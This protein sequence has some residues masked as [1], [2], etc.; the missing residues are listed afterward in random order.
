[1][2]R[3]G[4]LR[5]EET[6]EANPE[7]AQELEETVHQNLIQQTEIRGAS[8]AATYP[9]PVGTC[10][11]VRNLRNSNRDNLANFLPSIGS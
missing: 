10:P 9:T 5:L 2:Q 3:I 6:N 4:V 7:H 8:E 11:R 1:M